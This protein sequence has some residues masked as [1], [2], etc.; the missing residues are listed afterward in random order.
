MRIAALLAS[1][2]ILSYNS[3]AQNVQNYPYF[4]NF[5]SSAWQTSN[6]PLGKGITDPNWERIDSIDY[7]W[8]PFAG[9]DQY[10]YSGPNRDFTSGTGK[11]LA[12]HGAANDTSAFIFTPYIDLSTASVPTLRFADYR[13]GSS[14]QKLVVWAQVWNSTTWDSVHVSVGQNRSS[15]T[16]SWAGNSIDLSSFAGDTIRIIFEANG[17]NESSRTIAIDDLSITELDTC[18]LPMSIYRTG[19]TSSSITLTWTK[20]YSDSTYIRILKSG[21]PFSNAQ[22]IAVG[23]TNSY[24]F[25]GLELGQYYTFWATSECSFHTGKRW[26][27]ARTERTQCGI[28][29][30][31]FSEN[32][33][34]IAWQDSAQNIPTGTINAC[35]I[36][37]GSQYKI[38]QPTTASTPMRVSVPP[39]PNGSTKWMQYGGHDMVGNHNSNLL[40][41]FF[42]LPN[43]TTFLSFWYFAQGD[44]IT[45]LRVMY[46]TP[47]MTSYV[48]HQ[49]I[50]LSGQSANGLWKRTN[51][52]L[53]ALANQ[54]V[55]IYLQVTYAYGTEPNTAI[56]AMDD[57]LIT[58]NQPCIVNL[59]MQATSSEFNSVSLV[60]NSSSTQTIQ[61]GLKGFS[62]GTGTL[63][64]VN[65]TGFTVSSLAASSEY[66]FYL[67]S[68]C[69]GDT[70]WLGPVS[71]KTDCLPSSIP[72][73][74]DFENPE[75]S[76]PT[77]YVP[78][79]NQSMFQ[80]CWK[81]GSPMD[82]FYFTISNATQQFYQSPDHS[83][84]I[85]Q[86]ASAHVNQTSPSRPGHASLRSPLFD[87]SA[88]T[89]PEVRFWYKF[90]GNVAREL[91]VIIHGT[92]S[93]STEFTLPHPTHLSI[94]EDWQEAIIDLTSY[95]GDTIRVEIKSTIDS[96]SSGTIIP[97]DVT[98]L[99]DDFSISEQPICPDATNLRSTFSTENSISL[100]WN[101]R[102]ANA[103]IIEYG[104]VG[105][106]RGSGNTATVTGGTTTTIGGLESSTM[107]DFYISTICVD[108][109]VPSSSNIAEAT[110]C[111]KTTAPLYV[112]FE[113]EVWRGSPTDNYRYAP[114]WDA[115][116]GRIGKDQMHNFPTPYFTGD[117]TTGSGKYWANKN[118]L[119]YGN[120]GL[121]TPRIDVSQLDSAELRFW[122]Y[123]FKLSRFDSV[124]VIV[125]SE[126]NGTS[127]N[128]GK[129]NFTETTPFVGLWQEKVIDLS[130][131]VGDTIQIF[132]KV[133]LADYNRF[134]I[135]DI[136]IDEKANCTA[137]ANLTARNLNTNNIELNW[138]VSGATNWLVFVKPRNGLSSETDTVS[139]TGAPVLIR[140][141]EPNLQYEFRV[142]SVCPTGG[143]STWS[144]PAYAETHDSNCVYFLKLSQNNLSTQGSVRI[145]FNGDPRTGK[146]YYWSTDSV[147]EYPISIPANQSFTLRYNGV[148]QNSS[149]LNR[150]AIELVDP[151]QNTL[152]SRVYQ[153]LAA[154]GPLN[155][156][157]LYTGMG[158]SCD[159]RC[160]GITSP[161]L[162]A[163]SYNSVNLSWISNSDSSEVWIGAQ[164]STPSS[165]SFH[166]STLSIDTLTYNTS[167]SIY[168]RDTCAGNTWVGPLDF[169]TPTCPVIDPSF[170]TRS[171]WTNLD[172]ISAMRNAESA[173][174]FTWS[175]GDGS[176]S[177]QPRPTHSYQRSGQY[178]ITLI[179]EDKCGE[180]DSSSQ[181][182]YVCD[183]L[184]TDFSYFV[185]PG[186]N[187]QFTPHITGAIA[188]YSWNFGD[189]SMS[190]QPNPA[191]SYS[192]F[193]NYSVTL[194]VTDSCGNTDSISYTV[195]ACHLP[196]QVITKSANGFS[197]TFDAS[198]SS[199]VSTYSWN[200]DG[201]RKSGAIVTHTFPTYGRY[202]VTLKTTNVCGTTV[203]STFYY[204]ICLQPSA[205]WS[206]NVLS[207]STTHLEV[208]FNATQSIGDYY[209]WDFG[210]GTTADTIIAR[211]TFTQPYSTFLV[212]LVVTN[213][214]EDSATSTKNYTWISTPEWSAQNLVIY[215]NP[216]K[217]P[218]TIAHPE[219]TD[220][221]T[222]ITL[223][224]VDGKIIS[225]NVPFDRISSQQINVNLKQAPGTY[226]LSIKTHGNEVRIPIVI[227]P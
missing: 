216:T 60:T 67:R 26:T 36:R 143:L 20:L 96:T 97:S 56:F 166:T 197:C 17:L 157:P 124:N 184:S 215:P 110:S 142:K 83:S 178:Q 183:S 66:D 171:W 126:K 169:T 68:V 21:D 122:F 111:T 43:R 217:G 57:F 175:F 225:E 40:T 118:R 212:S 154:R 109:I 25:T 70:F 15:S 6:Q 86:Y 19:S 201:S 53:S 191:H 145:Y 135:D 131:F 202:K 185:N 101:G 85:G 150:I 160:S 218:I 54:T 117:H 179:V 31:P 98:I 176:S 89:H 76:M 112:D 138:D 22:I 211:H 199:N 116:D 59:D 128:F 5:E 47:S 222:K 195:E 220:S 99:I 167:Y 168:L 88:S 103:W 102:G 127:T 2:C 73:F 156:T 193:G 204:Q 48:Q 92:S 194:T 95:A 39:P 11:Y 27:P 93:T 189:G 125:H 159:Y 136:S 139:V 148:F 147:V 149:N 62:L 84:G 115:S 219:G 24:E 77:P 205:N 209:H 51:I 173:K 144:N 45:G 9:S 210:D 3:F 55:Q 14:I 91:N 121:T 13:Y 155:T 61:Y 38:W 82:E 106:A 119:Q 206:A 41:P 34:G 170:Q 35:W 213:V 137:P 123:Q 10:P 94:N 158:Q 146:D 74:T 223:G 78:Q 18:P 190:S 30:L 71:A 130:S 203:D 181:T 28:Q 90:S 75:F 16:V 87:L 153:G 224:T 120:F 81:P 140:D 7:Y 177:N 187:V 172:F 208:E 188:T 141:L 44:K 69:G 32:F 105:F 23:D 134:G 161:T 174:Y 46:R 8:M 1:V 163:I 113:D 164:G 49:H 186:T 72:Y 37:G 80:S 162:S 4:E 42:Q 221:N 182:L 200:I 180:I 151:S 198:T 207:Q 192:S 108:T 33:E 214:C 52:N 107:Y 165:G 196:T 100:E 63:K 114:C 58:T 152:Y 129:L 132:W 65:G 12:T 64:Q 79:E 226:I 50:S 227:Q 29:S 133:R 104:P